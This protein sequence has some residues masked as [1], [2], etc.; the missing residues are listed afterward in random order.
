MDSTPFMWIF[1]LVSYIP[2]LGILSAVLDFYWYWFAD[3]ITFHSSIA[4]SSVGKPGAHNSVMLFIDFSA[5]SG[6]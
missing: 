6:N 3:Y 2:K 4:G 1:L 5:S